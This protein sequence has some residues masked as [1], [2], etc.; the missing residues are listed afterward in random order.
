MGLR[1]LDVVDGLDQSIEEV[2]VVEL[3]LGCIALGLADGKDEVDALSG[4]TSDLHGVTFR[5]DNGS[6]YYP[7]KY[8]EQRKLESLVGS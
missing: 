2:V 5:V 7:C 4:S 1:L 8:R 3:G 6:H